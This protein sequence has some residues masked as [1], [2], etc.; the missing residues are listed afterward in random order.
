MLSPAIYVFLGPLGFIC[1]ELNPVIRAVPGWFYLSNTAR[2]ISL[3]PLLLDGF[4][5]HYPSM[6]LLS[7]GADLRHF[8]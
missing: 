8:L 6:L 4:L 7:V 3:R 5:Y 1:L 2:T